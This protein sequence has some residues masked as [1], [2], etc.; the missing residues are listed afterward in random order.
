MIFAVFDAKTVEQ[1]TFSGIFAGSAYGLLGAGFAL[2]LGV[3]GR[4]HFAYSFTYTLAAY[5]CFT[6]KDR[7]G[8]P[9]W[10][11]AILGV[12]VA[13]AAGVVIELAIYHPLANRA[14]ATALLSVFV[15]SLGLGIA[16]SAMVSLFWTEQTQ[17]F[18][19][20]T[21]PQKAWTFHT[22]N[23]TNFDVY[24]TLSA[25]GFVLIVGALLRFTPLGR[26]I[27]ATRVNPELAKVIGINSR[28]VYLV[29]FGIGTFLAG[30]AAFWYALQYTVVPTMGQ[31]PV[32]FAFAVAF[33]AGTAS[34]PI[35]VYFTG[36]GVGLVEKYASIWLSVQW[37]E[38][39]VF[40]I[41]VVYLTSLSLRGKKL[42]DLFPFLRLRRARG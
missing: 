28:L 10:W 37:T 7:S 18:Y 33:L 32:I 30:V 22:S 16:G 40:A 39:A 1:L 42:G 41:L 21:L 8:I 13:T 5:M 4:F 36:M 38:T 11:A 6:F 2:I 12:L 24:Q 9:F 34:S 35:R 3:T 31:R 26:A 27:K 14:G 20:E 15:A 29:V 25:L 17:A 19:D 23:F